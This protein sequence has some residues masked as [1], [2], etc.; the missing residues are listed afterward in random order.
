ME[1]DKQATGS[2]TQDRQA[3]SRRDFLAK[4]AVAAAGLAIVSACRSSDQANQPREIATSSNK[5][6]GRTGRKVR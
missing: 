5:A 6:L 2:N 4:G 1:K 3:Q